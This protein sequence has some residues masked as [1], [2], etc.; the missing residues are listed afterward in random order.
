MTKEIIKKIFVP[1]GIL[2]KDDLLAEEKDS[3]IELMARKGMPET[4]LRRRLYIT[5]F[6]KWELEGIANIKKKYLELS[7]VAQALLTYSGDD[8][9]EGDK[10][11]LYTLAKS[12]ENGAFYNSITEAKMCVHFQQYM[13]ER[14]MASNT[15]VLDRFSNENWKPFELS[16]I[17]AIIKKWLDESCH[18]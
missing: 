16:G 17:K 4:T 1:G 14:G 9:A 3:L 11:Y 18:S 10:G 8:Y 12:D 5:G 6:T 13:K 15:T 2:G 7:D